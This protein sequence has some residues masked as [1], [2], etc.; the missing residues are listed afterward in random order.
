M[1]ALKTRH[2]LAVAG[3][4][5]L[6][7]CLNLRASRRDRLVLASWTLTVTMVMPSQVT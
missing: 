3:Y 2:R 7:A 5:D 1:H 4:D 6:F